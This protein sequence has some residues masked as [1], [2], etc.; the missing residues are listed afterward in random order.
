MTQP[1]SV[2]QMVRDLLSQAIRDGIVA[3]AHSWTDADPQCRT[4]GE[5]IGVAN[6]LT[7]MLADRVKTLQALLNRWQ[8]A[9]GAPLEQCERMAAAEREAFH[10]REAAR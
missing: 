1:L 8:A 7:S 3:P 10:R 9:Y 2:E 6:L 5:L 4:A